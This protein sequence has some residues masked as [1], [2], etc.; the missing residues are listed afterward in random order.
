VYSRFQN[1]T[2]LPALPVSVQK[3]QTSY[4]HAR[5]HVLHRDF[6]IYII[7]LVYVTTLYISGTPWRRC[8]YGSS[9]VSI[10]IIS[11]N[12]AGGIEE[13]HETCFHLSGALAEILAHNIPNIRLKMLPLR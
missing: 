13:N 11:R 6:V 5:P 2:N 10:A 1:P 12:L 9:R 4:Q 8:W 3:H 7:S